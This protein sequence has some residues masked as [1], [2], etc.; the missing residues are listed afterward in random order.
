MLT[1]ILGSRAVMSA[2]VILTLVAGAAV[3]LRVSRP[4][5][6]T[7]GYCADMPDAVGL[8][9]GSAVTIMGVPVGEVTG[10]QLEGTATRVRFT[11]RADRKL[12]L[13][14]GATTVSDTLVADRKLAL[15]G[16]EPS[17]ASWN[18]GQCITKTVTPKS[19]TETFDALAHLADQ[20]DSSDDPA[21]R[22][23]LGDG[24]AAL[25]NATGGSG[26][27]INA[28]INQLGN[29]LAAPDAAIGHLGQL[30]DAIG[31]LAHRAHS[32]WG[33]VHDTVT[34]LPRTF[35]DI[36]VIAFP[37]IIDLV[38]ALSKLLPQINDVIIMLGSPA[39][40]SLNSVPNLSRLLTAGVGSLAEIIGMVPA[41]ATGFSSA[42]DPASGRLN[43][44]YAAPEIALAQP[45]TDQICVAVQAVTGQQCRKSENGAVDVPVLPV[46]LSAVSAR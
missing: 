42:I 15:I 29:A 20:L 14:V 37:P 22:H 17:G 41:I 31:E 2:A 39:L 16:A 10:I 4:H 5:P 3:G 6:A 19:L 25:D 7:Q 40:R 30:L 28:I 36:N 9:T 18:P 26:D 33:Q 23:A 45:D 38:D 35:T 44:G 43:I 27:Q 12:P 8:F 32:G 1:R 13:D 21:Q 34:G 24:M 11:V 46:L